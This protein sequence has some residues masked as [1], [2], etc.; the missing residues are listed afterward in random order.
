MILREVL[1]LHNQTYVYA[2]EDDEGV[3]LFR[4]KYTNRYS[5]SDIHLIETVFKFVYVIQ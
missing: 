1:D 2:I 3:F 5:I 4:W